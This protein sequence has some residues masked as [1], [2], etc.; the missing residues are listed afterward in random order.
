M[1]VNEEFIKRPDVYN[2]MIGGQGGD[3]WTKLGHK[4]SEET[5]K[6]IS[7]CSKKALKR[8]DVRKKLSQ[9]QKE[10]W[11]RIK[12]NKEFYDD[13]QRR[14]SESAKLA[15]KNRKQHC[16]TNESRQKISQALLAHYDK[17]GRKKS[18]YIAQPYRIQGLKSKPAVYV[19]NGQYEFRIR[20]EEVE[21]YLQHGYQLGRNPNNKKPLA[22]NQI[23]KD[24][25]S[26]KGKFII[27]NDELQQLRRINPNE[28]DEY[29]ANGWKRGYLHKKS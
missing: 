10:A 24:N 4:H 12:T 26:G 9:S 18:K 23:M 7:E 29:L 15:Y 6:K 20:K 2:C 25:S 27:H 13:I 5:K 28:L 21:I 17:V 19:T 11:K 8:S 22:R 14:R 3:T 16:Q 1:V